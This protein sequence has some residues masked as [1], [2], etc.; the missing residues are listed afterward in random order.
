MLL[1][2]LKYKQNRKHFQYWY[3]YLNL[4]T[5]QILSSVDCDC[6]T[7][8]FYSVCTLAQLLLCIWLFSLKLVE[9]LGIIFS[10]P[11]S[12]FFPIC[13]SNGYSFGKCT[14]LPIPQTLKS[15]YEEGTGIKQEVTERTETC[16]FSTEWGLLGNVMQHKA[17]RAFQALPE[18]TSVFSAWLNCNIQ[19]SYKICGVNRLGIRC[20]LANDSDQELA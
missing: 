20:Q 11:P 2:I 10:F 13:K 1:S 16:T 12:V 17:L 3:F 14:P 5:S 4:G 6:K 18:S 8:H 15:K 9:V 7:V 19:C